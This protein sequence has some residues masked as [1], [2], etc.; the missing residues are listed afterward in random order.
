MSRFTTEVRY[1]CESYAGLDESKG[2]NDVENIIETAAPLIFGD[3]P[4]YD[5]SYRLVLEKKILRHY[6]TRE[7]SEETVGLWKLRLMDKMCLIMPFYNK[8]Y[9]S[10]LLSFNPFYDVDLTRDYTRK[11]DGKSSNLGTETARETAERNV[12][13]SGSGSAI[14]NDSR[15]VIEIGNENRSVK[16]GGSETTSGNSSATSNNNKSGIGAEKE[17]IDTTDSTSNSNTVTQKGNETRSKTHWDLYSDTPQGSVNGIEAAEPSIGS[18]AYL[19]NAR[20]LTDAETLAFGT[21]N[22][23]RQELNVGSSETNRGG[24]IDKSNNYTENE[25]GGSEQNFENTVEK[26]LDT[27]ENVGENRNRQESG[28]VERSRND[29]K[30]GTYSDKMSRD[31]QSIGQN[32]ISNMSE[33]I[34]HVVGK[35]GGHTFS[36]MLLEFRDTFLNIDAMIIRDL[37]PLFFGLWE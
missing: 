10:E 30:T 2:G 17:N 8:L 18:N 33:Y 24:S 36:K 6:Y 20:K 32:V 15:S 1:I 9:E 13:E 4:I 7:I 19:T 37:E 28:S 29:S 23:A 14:D 22:A 16:E 11:D 21:G 34:E 25:T 5:E 35:Q 31:S 26:N 12:N 27:E 3:F